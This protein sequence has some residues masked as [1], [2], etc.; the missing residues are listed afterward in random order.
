MNS[1]LLS[2]RRLL[3]TFF[4]CLFFIAFVIN[5]HSQRVSGLVR[6]AADNQPL[7]GV[8]VQVKGSSNGTTTDEKGHYMLN[9]SSGDSLFFSYIGFE[10]KTVFINNR[11]EVNISLH[12]EVSSLD[13]VVVVGYGTQKKTSLTAAVSTMK[14]KEI[15]SIPISNLS[16]ALG[17]RMSGVIFRQGSGEPGQDA[18]RI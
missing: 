14:G 3:P 1:T 15:S 12:V 6:S 18:S 9:T 17:G 5:A 16:N 8:S 4:S 7:S 10:N 13:Q 11:T 2:N